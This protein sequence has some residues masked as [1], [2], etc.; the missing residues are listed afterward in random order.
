MNS[1]IFGSVLPELALRYDTTMQSA[2][3]TLT[4]FLLGMGVSV[5][6]C[7]PL[8][9]LHGRKRVVCYM[10]VCS[11]IVSCLSKWAPSLKWYLIARFIS[12]VF[13]APALLVGGSLLKD[14]YDDKQ[15]AQMLWTMSL[16]IASTPSTSGELAMTLMRKRVI[17]D[18]RN[19][20][21]VPGSIVLGFGLLCILF[22][23][24][25]YRPVI[26]K[27]IANEI[28]R[29]DSAKERVIK[30]H[31]IDQ[32]NHRIQ[33]S[34][35]LK[36]REKEHNGY[37]LLLFQML[38][39]PYKLLGDII[40]ITTSITGAY[41]SGSMYLHVA[42]FPSTIKKLQTGVLSE[43]LVNM[44]TIGL[45]TLGNATMLICSTIYKSRYVG[46]GSI[47]PEYRLV[48]FIMGSLMVMT[49]EFLIFS[50]GPLFKN[51]IA[52]L[53]AQFLHGAGY[54][55]TQQSALLYIMELYGKSVASA[56]S[57][58][59]MLKC[60]LSAGII[61]LG[62]ELFLRFRNKAFLALAITNVLLTIWLT[63]I[64]FFGHKVRPSLEYCT[65]KTK[66]KLLTNDSAF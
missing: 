7:G 19:L 6:V 31:N 29:S 48:P 45:L 43:N 11:G 52:I 36:V 9:E 20:N 63:C 25:T 3:L 41:Y 54:F 27:R 61:V 37:W 28:N 16:C 5:I 66:R 21:L 47:L 10:T 14:M 35:E 51:N 17:T 38:L 46:N 65:V 4:M 13:E 26:S 32:D 34:S 24:E 40:I 33:F 44:F 23:P 50:S 56:T 42:S 53:L 49:S 12:G 18:V 22:V 2:S 60:T 39:L 64:L 58:F 8:T 59:L 55:L 57:L 1:S 62:S 30:H 15:R